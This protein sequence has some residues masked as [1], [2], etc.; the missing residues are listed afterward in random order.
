MRRMEAQLESVTQQWMNAKRAL[1]YAQ[2]WRYADDHWKPR[3][4]TD[5][6]RVSDIYNFAKLPIPAGTPDEHTRAE[7][8]S[9]LRQLID[10]K[11]ALKQRIERIIADVALPAYNAIR[12]VLQQPKRDLAK[13]KQKNVEIHRTHRAQASADAFAVRTRAALDAAARD[14]P[15][16]AG[17]YDE[18][19]EVYKAHEKYLTAVSRMPWRDR[20][21]AHGAAALLDLADVPPVPLPVVAAP[22]LT[23]VVERFDDIEDD[24]VPPPA[25]GAG[26]LGGAR[27][28]RRRRRA[29]SRKSRKSRR[30]F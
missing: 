26:A 12:S 18:A 29:S 14:L 9:G 23:G 19:D 10:S 15:K 3:Q 24:V 7:I 16:L 4:S 13:L 20:A 21:H 22:D 27:R 30:R 1:N 11:L 8:E 2:E 5:V 28:R 17:L 25:G 6:I